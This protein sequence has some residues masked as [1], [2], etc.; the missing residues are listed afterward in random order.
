MFTLVLQVTS[1]AR[2]DESGS[3]SSVHWCLS[4]STYPRTYVFAP[5]ASAL[6]CLPVGSKSTRTWITTCWLWSWSGVTSCSLIWRA[7]EPRDLRRLQEVCWSKLQLVPASFGRTGVSCLSWHIS[8]STH[9]RCHEQM[10]NLGDFKRR[11]ACQRLTVF[12]FESRKSGDQSSVAFS[13]D[14]DVCV[15]YSV[16]S[17]LTCLITRSYI[18]SL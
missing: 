3:C 13:C 6:L 17:S 4:L 11:D 10:W 18:N 14:S 1:R 7:Q 5:F 16:N 15:W 8:T 12:R 2:V 9:V